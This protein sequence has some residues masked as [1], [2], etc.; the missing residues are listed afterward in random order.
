MKIV[1]SLASCL[2]AVVMLEQIGNWPT[3][4]TVPLQGRDI[5]VA[6]PASPQWQAIHVLVE[7]C[8]C[9][10]AVASH[11]RNR[12]PQPGWQEMV[13]MLGA[14]SAEPIPG[15]TVTVPS[16]ETIQAA[17]LVGGPRLLLFAPA[18]NL[19]WTGGYRPRNSREAAPM[20]DLSAMLAVSRGER[21]AT[22]PVYGC[23]RRTSFQSN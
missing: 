19:L 23:P 3:V 1:L 5:A 18:G 9:S 22:V 14:A 12:G 11:L 10:R 16:S 6:L 17:G 8:A 4:H 13:W 15:F 7:G 20:V 21:A 2:W